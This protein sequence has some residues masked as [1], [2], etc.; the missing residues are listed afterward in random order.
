MATKFFEDYGQNL[1]YHPGLLGR[2]ADCEKFHIHPHYELMVVPDPV[3]LDHI[4]CGEHIISDYPCAV[5]VSPFIP[6]FSNTFPGDGFRFPRYLWYFGTS[7][8]HSMHND[9]AATDLLGNGASCIINI[10]AQMGQIRRLVSAFEGLPKDSIERTY[11]LEV[12]LGM[13]RFSSE[14]STQESRNVIMNHMEHYII[15][16]INY[17]TTHLSEKCTTDILAEKFFV[18]QDKLRK[19]F[20]RCTYVNIGEFIQRM[21]LNY[22]RE[23]LSEQGISVSE[24]VALCG[25]ES[26]SYFYKLF[27]AATGKTPLEYKKKIWKSK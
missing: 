12:I 22:A 3:K 6:H 4:I 26:E 20:K 27:R 13:L 19:D 25:Y 23:L 1:T 16:V 10:S 24:V 17:I 9:H 5:L 7:V 11:L 2:M 21:R 8:T 18:S 15:E 14:R